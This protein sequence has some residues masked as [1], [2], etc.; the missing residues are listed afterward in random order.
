MSVFVG[1]DQISAN[2]NPF[3]SRVC[4]RVAFIATERI[5]GEVFAVGKHTVFVGF[6]LKIGEDFLS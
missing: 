5:L 3:I 1:V 4:V 6:T 2:W